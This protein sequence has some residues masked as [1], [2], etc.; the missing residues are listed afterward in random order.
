MI[1]KQTK[2]IISLVLV[3]VVIGAVL[4]F[5]NYKVQMSKNLP[6]NISIDSYQKEQAQKLISELKDKLLTDPQNLYLKRD[7]SRAYY[8]IGEL[9]NAEQIIKE[10]MSISNQD[11]QLYVD[12]GRI[13]EARGDFVKAE[14]QYKKAID[15]M[16]KENES[17]VAS[18]VSQNIPKDFVLPKQNENTKENIVN[19][20]PTP[21]TSLAQLY[22]NQKKNIE[23]IDVLNSGI[24]IIPSYPD[25]YLKLSE[26]YAKTGD[27][28]KSKYYEE[29]FQKLVKPK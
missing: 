4:Y 2:I 23:A 27:I 5:M 1:Q 15:L 6:A 7:L 25:F 12:S 14:E 3:F 20:T 21:F 28:T 18:E 13:Y 16:K 9:D 10:I 8:L 22:I 24:K 26:I 19:F 11:L 17:I 29:Q